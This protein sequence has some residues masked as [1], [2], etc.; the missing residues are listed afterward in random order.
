MLGVL[1]V[2]LTKLILG[3]PQNQRPSL[4]IM[5]ASIKFNLNIDIK[6][7]SNRKNHVVQF[8]QAIRETINNFEKI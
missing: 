4:V 6:A 7:V 3:L 1:E 2:I 5:H 8:G